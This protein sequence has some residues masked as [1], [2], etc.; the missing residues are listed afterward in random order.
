[1]DEGAK[2]YFDKMLDGI[3]TM[4]EQGLA[5]VND[6]PE[7][8]KM[9]RLVALT[10]RKHHRAELF[11]KGLGKP[12]PEPFPVAEAAK[13]LFLDTLQSVLDFLF[14][15][16]RETQHGA[17]Q[18][19]S[20]NML[21]W[22][23]DELTVAFYLA[24]RKYTTQ[25]HSHLRTVLD[26]LDRAELFSRE[27][28]LAEVW[29]GADKRKILKELQPGSVRAKL[30]KPRFDPV[31]DFFTE[32]G[33]HGTFAA[34]RQRSV[35]R[36]RSNANRSFAVWLGGVAWDREVDLAV[37]CCIL[38]ALLTLTTVA[39]VYWIR[40]HNEEL[41][42]TIKNKADSAQGFLQEHL[43]KP[44]RESRLEGPSLADAFDQLL[45]SIRTV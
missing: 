26:L 32:R 36:E 23:V 7:K 29:G 9:L 6:S 15:A 45:V 40:L 19:A 30:G 34:V 22:S 21:Y 42:T 1:M 14:D 20:L 37:S 16:T 25:A 12:L 28:G 27:P 2:A 10:K 43:V 39:K 4:Y 18:F 38:N 13:P 35:Q 8:R 24:E 17:G 33:M 41:A 44:V 3:S 5:R 31:Y 11:L